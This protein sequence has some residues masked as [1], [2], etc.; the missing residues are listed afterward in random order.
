MARPQTAMQAL[1]NVGQRLMVENS[2]LIGAD[3]PEP[4]RTAPAARKPPGP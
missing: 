4:T 2:R 1:R 3:A